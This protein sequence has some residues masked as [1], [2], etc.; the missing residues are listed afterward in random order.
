MKKI[1]VGIAFIAAF[2]IPLIFRSIL[3]FEPDSPLANYHLFFAIIWLSSGLGLWLWM[4]SDLLKRKKWEYK[5]FWG[6]VLFSLFWFGAVIYFIIVVV[7]S[8]K[9]TGVSNS[10]DQPTKDFLTCIL[11]TI[12][13]P[14]KAFRILFEQ[15]NL[16]YAV[17]ILFVTG[18]V[19]GLSGVLYKKEES[20]MMVMYFPIFMGGMSVIGGGF[21]IG[22]NALYVMFVLSF[23]HIKINFKP[24]L[25]AITFTTVPM[26]FSAMIDIFWPGRR[27]LLHPEALPKIA[28]S[29]T[30]L[31]QFIGSEYYYSHPKMFAFLSN[32]EPFAIWG[33]ILEVTAVAIIANIAYKKS[34]IIMF[35]LW[36]VTS[37]L[38]TMS[39][40]VVF[41]Q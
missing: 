5:F 26:L 19:I 41:G 37:L 22:V 32:I 31:A 35:P 20:I 21:A 18:M 40:G 3:K 24:L 13:K 1:T 29:K 6:A 25:S 10:N 38:Y 33:F 36:I 9:T 7:P 27:V 23:L 14:T 17:G 15:A 28:Y 2:T 30:S 12:T 39:L 11:L 34:F 16:N 8:K 4:V